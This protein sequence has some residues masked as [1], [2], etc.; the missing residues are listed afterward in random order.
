[1][2]TNADEGWPSKINVWIGHAVRVG[3]RQLRGRHHGA[4]AAHY[5]VDAI[6]ADGV[7]SLTHVIPTS[8]QNTDG[9]FSTV[10]HDAA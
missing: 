7:G 3:D 6:D 9:T 1:M 5:R 10:W 8:V 2:K 4:Y